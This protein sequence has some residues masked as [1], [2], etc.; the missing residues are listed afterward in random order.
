[1]TFYWKIQQKQKKLE[2]TNKQW[3]KSI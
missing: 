2:E 3:I 1:L